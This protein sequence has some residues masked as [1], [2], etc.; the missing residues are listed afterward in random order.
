MVERD[1]YKQAGAI[2][3]Q[4]KEMIA[5]AESIALIPSIYTCMCPEMS[6]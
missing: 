2:L 5:M 1:L 6:H 3:S 4:D